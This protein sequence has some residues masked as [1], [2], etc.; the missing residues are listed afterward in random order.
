MLVPLF[1]AVEQLLAQCRIFLRVVAAADGTGQRHA[2]QRLP[3]HLR[4]QFRRGSEEGVMRA[5][6][7]KEAVAVVV[8][9]VQ[10]SQCAV[11][12]HPLPK[13]QL[14]HPRQ[15]HFFERGGLDLANGRPD[16]LR[17]FF[18]SHGVVDERV[19]G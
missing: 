13:A 19:N 17:P 12:V 3:F 15:H 1:G 2:G 11:H 16:F 9:L 6:L 10:I 4:Q 5:R 8:A 7:K 14:A 18:I